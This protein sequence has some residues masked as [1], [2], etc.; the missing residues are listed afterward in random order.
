MLQADFRIYC[1]DDDLTIHQIWKE[2]LEEVQASAKNIEMLNFTSAIEF[3][4]RVRSLDAQERTKNV[5][6]I[7][8][9]LLDQNTNGLALIEELGLGQNAVLV[10]SHYEEP[11]IQLQCEKLNTKL[12]PKSLVNLFL[13]KRK[14]AGAKR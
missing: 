12:L 6:L 8:Y 3:K 14:S 2:R 7:D 13:L 1:L 9:E 10:T 4:K 11:K 5:F